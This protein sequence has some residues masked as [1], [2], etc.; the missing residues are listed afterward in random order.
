ML[1]ELVEDGIEVRKQK[2]KEFFEAA[3]RFRAA[4]DTNEAERL[5]D[6]LGRMVFGR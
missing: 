5:G 1:A 3:E 4:A 6:Q 2:E